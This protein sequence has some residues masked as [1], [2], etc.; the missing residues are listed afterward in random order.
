MKNYSFKTIKEV[1]DELLALPPGESIDFTF[2]TP[3]DVT[4]GFEPSGWFG[5]KITTLFDEKFGLLCFGYY[6]GG[7]L[8][9]EEIYDRKEI[10]NILQRF[11]DDEACTN[12]KQ[13]CVSAQRNGQ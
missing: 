7:G 12:V 1:A 10:A 5:V 3:D 4:E 8:R 6:G 9:I 13:L 11:C 2:D